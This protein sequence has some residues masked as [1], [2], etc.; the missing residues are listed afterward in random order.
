MAKFKSNA[1]DNSIRFTTTTI[2]MNT[3][4]KMEFIRE[5]A[6]FTIIS[7]QVTFN[8]PI[9]YF[10]LREPKLL[11]PSLRLIRLNDLLGEFFLAFSGSGLARSSAC[12]NDST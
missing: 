4:S 1:E 9:F 12:I 3:I 6:V 10:Q 2:N 7:G 11:L 5:E 8:S